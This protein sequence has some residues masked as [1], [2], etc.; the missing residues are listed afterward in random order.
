MFGKFKTL[1][2]TALF[3][4]VLFGISACKANV[5]SPEEEIKNETTS[6]NN[7]NTNSN[8]DSGNKNGYSLQIVNYYYTDLTISVGTVK[9]TENPAAPYDWNSINPACFKPYTTIRPGESITVSGELRDNEEFFVHAYNAYNQENGWGV[10]HR[11]KR[12][13]FVPNNNSFGFYYFL[14]LEE[15][16]TYDK[17]DEETLRSIE[18]TNDLGAPVLVSVGDIKADKANEDDEK[19]FDLNDRNDNSF[20][21]EYM[22][23][24]YETIKVYGNLPAG[25]NFY[26]SAQSLY[27]DNPQGSNN[28]WGIPRNCTSMSFLGYSDDK[29]YTEKFFDETKEY[30]VIIPDSYAGLVSTGD[31]T[32]YM[33]GETV[34]LIITPEEGK[35]L[36][37]LMVEGNG[38][39]EIPVTNYEF[40][41]PGFDVYI[42]AYFSFGKYNVNLTS[43]IKNGK[44][45]V[46]PNP[47]EFNFS[48][49]MVVTPDS[50]YE[51]DTLTVIDSKGNTID[52]SY[53]PNPVS[54][55][56]YYYFTMPACDVNIN[57]TFKAIQY[58]V[59]LSDNIANGSISVNKT[60]AI[61]GDKI[62]I[63]TTPAAG[64]ELNEI[65]VK[66]SKGNALTVTNNE[67]TMPA[68]EVIISGSFKPISYNV[69]IAGGITNGTVAVNKTTASIGETVS[70]TATPATGYE[71]DAF[72][73]KDANGTSIPVTNNT[74]T[75][76]ASNVTI[77][78]SFKAIIYKVNIADGYSNGTVS[79]NKTGAVIGD[80]I[81]ISTAPDT[82]YVLNSI[83][84]KDAK[85]NIISVSNNEFT[86]PAGEVII[87]CSFRAIL[88]NVS[89]TAG[90]KNGIISVSQNQAVIGQKIKIST[91]A[92]NGYGLDTLSVTDSDG[93]SIAVTN[94]EFTMPARNV[95]VSG[96]FKAVPYTINID[97]GITH[98]TINISSNG[99]TVGDTIT[100][101]ISPDSYYE[102]DTLTVKDTQGNDISVTNNKFT[103]PASNVTINC[104]FK[105]ISYSVNI[106]GE[107]PNGTVSVDK[108]T[109]TY[110]EKVKISAT[111]DEGYKLSSL[112]VKDSSGNSLT[113]K[114][115]E[116]TMPGDNVTISCTFTEISYT[117]KVSSGILNGTIKVNKSTATIGNIIKI[118]TTPYT[119]YELDSLIVKDAEGNVVIV[120]ENEFIMPA[121]NVTVGGSFKATIY[122]VNVSSSITNGTVSVNKNTA[123]YGDTITITTSPDSD[124]VLNT[125]TVKKSNGTTVSVTGKQFT[126]PA[127]DVT[128]SCTFRQ[129]EYKLIITGNTEYGT[130]TTTG[131]KTSY[132][133][134]DTVSF[135]IKP[136][137]NY[138]LSSYTIKDSTGNN[139]TVNNKQFTMP[140]N[141]VTINVVFEEAHL[142]LKTGK[143]INEIL[144][145]NLN[146]NSTATS[147]TRSYSAPANNITTYLL[148]D[149]DSNVEVKVW[150]SN[151]N[152]YYYAESYTNLGRKIVLNPDS[153]EM[154]SGCKTLKSID[155]SCF[156]T[157]KVTN[158]SKMFEGCKALTSLD[159]SLDTSN[160]TDMSYMFSECSGFT[161]L[162]LSKFH[163]SKVID[164]SYM[165]NL[166]SNLTSITVSSFDTR[167]VTDMKHMF[168]N[169][170]QLKTLRITNF[171]TSNV[172]DMS[173]MFFGC[174]SVTS[175]NLSK[176]DTSNVTN[177]DGMFCACYK[178][179][180][181]DLST[182]NTS[183]VTSMRSM[184]NNCSVLTSL[185][186]S[187][188]N[189][190]KVTDM[191]CMFMR[192]KA[193]SSIDVSNFDTSN[194]TNMVGMF[195]ECEVLKT[196]DLSTFNTS[197]L[198]EMKNM[199][200]SCKAL[201]SLTLSNWEN[202]N[203]TDM[204]QMFD[205]CTALKTL[206]LST[207]GTPS[208]T[209]ME[210][211]F[212]NCTALTSLN[213]SGFDVSN[214]SNMEE[215]FSECKSIKTLDL[216]NFDT[217]KK[218]NECELYLWNMFY[219][220][221]NLTT[222]YATANF[223]P[224]K[225]YYSTIEMFEGCEKLKGGSGT[226][227]SCVFITSEYARIDDPKHD[228]EG[229]FT[230][231]Q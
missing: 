140:R 34:K 79:V 83:T 45:E 124:Y 59:N 66:D 18:L 164:M 16:N 89:I 156:D 96:S 86:M 71:F 181:L 174:T 88:Y 38:L 224:N 187:N 228:K 159:S 204:T 72:T 185:D 182:F 36:S 73:V 231:K 131:N 183:K 118:T 50:G 145:N 41:M 53:Y 68:D 91:T 212:Y 23:L 31:R 42:T 165:F 78:G 136:N 26:I 81:K 211:M 226:K 48:I 85:G 154:F 97:N 24:P 10:V 146:A 158:M 149:S 198:T 28:W 152:I 102:L 39:K 210:K 35:E 196:L 178:L 222:I 129:I 6:S 114:N 177:M 209:K 127:S 44:V 172:T 12:M 60:T 9:K 230:L 115:D 188:F 133:Y 138:I 13:I 151:T 70:L 201:T 205:S 219:N 161:S 29:M 120:T 77:S 179:T 100:I 109:A 54:R 203:V 208:V 98:G 19:N 47:A 106:S 107:S 1:S 191:C 30:K 25:R 52:Y 74:F 157:S 213:V 126:M 169:C 148:S 105:Q 162:D 189:T 40:T 130:V 75:M 99:G 202:T 111:P 216:S 108:Y 171:N 229:Y 144:I 56:P 194:V 121:S 92:E 14:T 61:I 143:E 119:G 195:R 37:T 27:N 220:D 160:V 3:A 163:T 190:S 142:S 57:G 58:K 214:V 90:I 168:D 63:T 135:S 55:I 113:I 4:I 122:N 112:T 132:A 199:F 76:P 21:S 217:T 147:F 64:Y 206:D 215:M 15:E 141:D 192:C 153:S 186:I 123:V 80:V 155:L 49:T 137:D 87:T 134:G 116:F 117:V 176:M 193:L 175:L 95:T 125:I 8:N 180:S 69:G 101:T 223:I 93:N 103:M 104:T 33:E 82:G 32:S 51:L 11:T 62:N 227:Y 67:F 139:I 22:L 46:S 2:V 200:Y 221:Y 5:D 7:T 166:C 110:G 150:L 218:A 17:N 225:G 170:G 207:F 184:F 20:L 167:N 128:I 43:D 197:N 173:Y 84:V 94:N 65:S